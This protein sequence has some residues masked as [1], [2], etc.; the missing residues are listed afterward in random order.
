MES[1]ELIRLS[2]NAL[3]ANKLRSGLTTLGIIIGVFAVILLVSIG[4]G[5][6]SY[7]TD[8][9]SGLGSNLIFVVP[10]T[11]AGGGPGGASVNKLTLIHAA[12]LEKGLSGLAKVAPVIM[13][14]ADIKNKGLEDKRVSVT[15]TTANYFQIIKTDMSS[16]IFFS[17]SQERSSSKVV[18]IGQTVADK[19]FPGENPIGQ[20]ISIS[21]GRYTVIGVIAKKGSAF[22]ED[23]DN[24]VM[25]PIGAAQRL[26]GVTN[27]STIYISANDFSTIDFVQRQVKDVLLKHLSENDFT[28][29]TQQQALS[30]ISNITNILTIALG[31][32]AAISLLVGGIGVMNI[33]LVSV[34]E[35]T[36]EIGL[37][38]AL[39]ARREDILKQFLLE[40][41]ILSLVGG[42]VGIILG[43]SASYV[44]SIVFVSVVTPWSVLLAFLFSVGIGVIF[45][46][47]PALRA[48]KL[49]PMEAL[50]YE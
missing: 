4:S 25:I 24:A 7:I 17:Q 8:Q 15:G 5:L 16:G 40:A 14:V 41:V 44:L 20:K 21:G 26:F 3:R 32:I 33:M 30:T 9:I 47:A 48:S 36:K 43:L 11:Q 45:G 38:K 28:V 34:T 50:R 27:I 2:L 12:E 29:E 6:Q 31:G 19:L 1:Q 37:R 10:G 46:I 35:R 39:G 18:D 23:Q 49:S 13:N 42:A 22:G